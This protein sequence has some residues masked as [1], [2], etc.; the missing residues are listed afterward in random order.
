MKTVWRFGVM[1]LAC[2]VAPARAWPPQDA[3]ARLGTVRFANSCGTQV[4][5]GFARAMAL[6]HSFEF[7]P[8]IDAF[9]AVATEDPSCAIASW[10]IALEI[11]RASCRER[12]LRLV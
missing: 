4:Q 5:P 10:G 6:L 7:G 3:G 12:V 9:G 8:A 2:L 1:S 11:G